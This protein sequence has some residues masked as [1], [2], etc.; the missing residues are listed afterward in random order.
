M[1]VVT[2]ARR[3]ESLPPNLACLSPSLNFC[4]IPSQFLI[5][6]SNRWM[7]SSSPDDLNKSRELGEVKASSSGREPSELNCRMLFKGGEYH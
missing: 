2:S 4:P 5:S 1:T 3:E 6:R 7:A